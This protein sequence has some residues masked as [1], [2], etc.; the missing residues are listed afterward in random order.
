MKNEVQTVSIG[1]VYA[2]CGIGTLIVGANPFLTEA[3]GNRVH[4]TSNND[5][6]INNF[7]QGGVFILGAFPFGGQAYENE[8]HVKMLGTHFVSGVD[9]ENIGGGGTRQDLFAAGA[10]LSVAENNNASLLLRGAISNGDPSFIVI[11]EIPLIDPSNE[12]KLIG[13]ETAI[14]KANE[15]VNLIIVE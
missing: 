4:F 7:K 14:E 5:Q 1:N 3:I 13:S 6:N 8:A 12:M 9:P 15:N 2:E 11:K 10:F